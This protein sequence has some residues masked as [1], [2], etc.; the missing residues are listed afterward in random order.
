MDLETF[1]GRAWIGR[2]LGVFRVKTATQGDV[3]MCVDDRNPRHHVVEVDAERFLG[4]WRKQWSSHLDVA[5]GDS[6]EW[7]AAERFRWAEAGFR[8][9]SRNPVPLALVGSSEVRPRRFWS[10][11][12]ANLCFLD[13]VVRTT[14]LLHARAEVFPVACWSAEDAIRLQEQAGAGTSAISIADLL[15]ELP[16]ERHFEM[17]EEHLEAG[18]SE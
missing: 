16:I 7:Q 8:H 18:S 11:S 14:W 9:G 4:L 3:F 12:Q 10:E 13:G 1:V 5:L 17:M 15:P 6:R 2:H